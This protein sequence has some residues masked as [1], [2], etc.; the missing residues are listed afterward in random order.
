MS[1][2]DLPRRE[3]ACLRLHRQCLQACAGAER[4]QRQGP[5]RLHLRPGQADIPAAVLP[6]AILQAHTGAA[7]LQAQA[8]EAIRPGLEAV[9]VIRGPAV[10]EGIQAAV[11]QAADI[12]VAALAAV[13]AADIPAVVAV[14]TEGK[15]HNV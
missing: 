12:P 2:E 9:A 8:V 15:F 13:M 4:L 11:T 6:R 1:E 5:R 7:A 14:A 3:Q 10:A